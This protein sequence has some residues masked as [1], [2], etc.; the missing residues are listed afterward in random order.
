MNQ[1][2]ISPGLLASGQSRETNSISI[3][4]P[5]CDEAGN[6]PFLFERF[7]DLGLQTEYIFI[8]G[9]SQDDSNS[10]IKTCIDQRRELNCRLLKQPGVGKADAVY[11]GLDYASG[12]LLIILDADLSID[13]EV[14]NDFLNIL[15]T[16]QGTF[17]TGNRFAFPLEHEAMPSMN[18]LGNKFFSQAFSLVTGKQIEDILC[19]V[20]TFRRNDYQKMQ[21]RLSRFMPLDPFGDFFLLYGAVKLA[22]DIIEVPVSYHKRRYGKSKIKPFWDGLKLFRFLLVALWDKFKVQN[23][24]I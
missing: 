24:K 17:I 22:L 5:V 12:D 1:K 14:L 3:I 23:H 20:K 9:H 11:F 4:I 6:I 18:S 21:Q 8:E 7:P 2:I 13:P 19:G 10:V 16:Q 15:L